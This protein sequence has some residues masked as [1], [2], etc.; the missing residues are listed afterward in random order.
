[1]F[2]NPVQ[3][4]LQLNTGESIEV[5]EIDYDREI[6]LKND[7]IKPALSTIFGHC[8]YV[9]R[10]SI[11]EAKQ[12]YSKKLCEL[13]R[14]PPLGIL[15]KLSMK[16]SYINNCPMSSHKE[17]STKNVSKKRGKF[18][19]CWTYETKEELSSEQTLIVNDIINHVF[20]AW[21]NGLYVLIVE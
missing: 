17:C 21:R 8:S 5:F 1:M 11:E 18:P 13:L 12:H 7:D 6:L 10:E 15:M 9:T 14:T 3:Y 20:Q 16:C 2:V 4:S 19:I